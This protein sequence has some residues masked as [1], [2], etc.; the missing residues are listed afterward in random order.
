MSVNYGETVSNPVTL[1][2]SPK[3]MTLTG[4]THGVTATSNQAVNVA[5]AFGSM[6]LSNLNAQI[7]ADVIARP[8][9]GSM[10]FTS[11][12]SSVDFVPV[13]GDVDVDVSTAGMTLTAQTPFVIAP[14]TFPV[15]N[16]SF[17][18]GAGDQTHDL[19][20][21]YSAFI[22]SGHVVSDIALASGSDALPAG[23][24]INVANE[25]LDFTD[26]TGI[27]ATAS[28]VLLEV[29]TESSLEIHFATESV[30]SGVFYSNNFDYA[31]RTA[32]LAD[33]HS[34]Q[35]DSA[36][37]G[38]KLDLETTIKLSGSGASRH[39]WFLAEGSNESGPAWNF[40]FDGKGAQTTNTKKTEFYYQYSIYVDQ[41]WVDFTYGGN[42]AIKTHII[43]NPDT[44]PFDQGEIVHTRR[45]AGPWPHGFRIGSGATNAWQLVWTVG[46][47]VPTGLNGDDTYYTFW[48]GGA[49]SESGETDY[50]SIN[51]FERRWGP[52]RNNQVRTDP[53][54]ANVPQFEGGKWYTIETYVNVS[55]SNSVVKH[56]FAERGQPP[57][58]LFGLMD[59]LISETINTYR[60]AHLISRA[61]NAQDD[62]SWVTQ[63][64]FICFDELIVSD[65]EIL[66][67]GGYSLPDSGI[68]TPS[69]WPPTGSA[70]RN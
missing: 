69:G 3:T 45:G 14:V 11:F 13:Q 44:A 58:L 16:I 50:T 46:A 64:T 32:Y 2:P 7:G 65:N 68:A 36:G 48:D 20:Q 8:G 27:P 51:L 17:T 34:Y 33:A 67:P 66:F 41:E 43:F 35:Y 38:N 55:G 28:S 54:Y 39:N 25:T 9:V 18:D 57:I 30:K 10:T 37:A 22:P 31:N 56:W 5:A 53:D 12:K 26:S 40:S 42:R 23:V 61:E 59:A 47:T 24:A 15:T 63:D 49:Q 52:R 29:T 4:L 70:P 21:Y 6:T 62:G 1:T 60:G 19:S